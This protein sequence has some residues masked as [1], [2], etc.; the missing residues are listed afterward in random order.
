VLAGRWGGRTCCSSNRGTLG[1]GCGKSV[2]A[3]GK[4]LLLNIS[5][6]ASYQR[7]GLDDL[8]LDARARGDSFVAFGPP[9]NKLVEPFLLE[10]GMIRALAPGV[11]VVQA[12]YARGHA[13]PICLL[14]DAPK[15]RT[16][17]ELL[18]EGYA[19][20]VNRWQTTCDIFRGGDVQS[21]VWFRGKDLMPN[22]E[23]CQGF[24]DCALLLARLEHPLLCDVGFER[25]EAAANPSLRRH[26][27][28]RNR[29]G[30][31]PAPWTTDEGEEL[32]K[33]LNV[34]RR[35]SWMRPRPRLVAA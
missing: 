29:G 15:W 3:P 4:D 6:V 31:L 13:Q 10:S 14:L 1:F 32:T 19:K 8:I 28:N 24:R 12:G 34:Y 23:D 27:L 2:D 22:M 16:A 33:W 11:V 25:L 9:V 5:M 30:L 7:V 35:R 26:R 18:P 20:R 17:V 21:T